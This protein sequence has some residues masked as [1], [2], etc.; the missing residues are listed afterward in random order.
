MTK[1]VLSKPDSSAVG[2]TALIS[3]FFFRRHKI[4]IIVVAALLFFAIIVFIVFRVQIWQATQTLRTIPVKTIETSYGKMAYAEKGSGIPIL[5]AHGTDGGYDQGLES[6]G[7]FGN[8][9]QAICPSRFGYPGSDM[10]K[11]ATPQAQADAYRQ[12]LDQLGIRKA[13][14]FGTSAGG[15]PA[16]QFALRYPDRT[17]GLVLL[18]SGMPVKQTAHEEVPTFMFNDFI[19]WIGAKVFPSIGMQQLGISSEEYKKASSADREQ[20]QRFLATMLPMTGRKDGF[21]NDMSANYDM[22][23]HYSDY[24]LEKIAVPVLI[25]HAKDDQFAKYSDTEASVCRL[26]NAT[27]AIFDHGGHMLFGDDVSGAIKSFVGK[28]GIELG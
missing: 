17:A 6:A 14:L 22:N 3:S 2:S 19:M 15:A 7:A 11:D 23:Y 9:Y 27:L 12:L 1:S 10:P 8:G 13:Y 26:P 4:M 28:N 24:P 25:L 16:M 18:S 20:I 21:V 5:I